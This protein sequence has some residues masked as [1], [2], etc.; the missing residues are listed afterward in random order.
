VA[1]IFCHEQKVLRPLAAVLG[2][3][4]KV[5]CQTAKVV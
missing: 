2:L 1:M 4:E 3:E 5:V